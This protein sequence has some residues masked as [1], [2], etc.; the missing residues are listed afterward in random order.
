MSL[1]SIRNLLKGFVIFKN[2][3]TAVN[4]VDR[5]NLNLIPGSANITISAVDNPGSNQVDVTI[6][7]A[8]GGGGLTHPQVLARTLG[9]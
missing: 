9:A 2:N 7:T 6:D 1:T 4:S 5:K 8:G 3:G